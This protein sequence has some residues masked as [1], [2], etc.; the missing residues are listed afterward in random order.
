[1]TLKVKQLPILKSLF[2]SR[3]SNCRIKALSLPVQSC[4]CW[5]AALLRSPHFEIPFF[6]SSSYFSD[7]YSYL[8]IFKRHKEADWNINL[9][10]LF[11]FLFLDYLV[12]HL[13]CYFIFLYSF[14]EH[15]F[16][17]KSR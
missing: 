9:V 13:Y 5:S 8:F 16:K 6:Y 4:R 17:K 1:M 2:Q 7:H 11:L 3:Q 15:I 12:L 14:K 10:F